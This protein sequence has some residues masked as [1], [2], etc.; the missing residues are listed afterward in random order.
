MHE[1]KGATEFQRVRCWHWFASL[2]RKSL[3]IESSRRTMTH[4]IVAKLREAVKEQK[5]E[6]L[7]IK[8]YR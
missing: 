2:K 6:K 4:S 3:H 8:K 7:K 5:I 1:Q